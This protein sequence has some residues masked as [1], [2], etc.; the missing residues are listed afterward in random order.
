MIKKN[1]KKKISSKE[2][3]ECSLGK[4]MKIKYKKKRLTKLLNYTAIW[5]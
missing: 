1:I 5:I 4:Y 3:K 2:S